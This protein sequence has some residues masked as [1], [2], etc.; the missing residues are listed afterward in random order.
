MKPTIEISG[1]LGYPLEKGYRAFIRQEKGRMLFTSQVVDVRNQSD[2]GVEIE[3]MNT[4]YKLTFA[5]NTLSEA[6]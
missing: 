6:A 4:I 5:K 3:T 2:E 1:N